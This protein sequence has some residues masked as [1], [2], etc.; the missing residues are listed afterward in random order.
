MRIISSE[1]LHSIQIIKKNQSLRI[2]SVTSITYTVSN[3]KQPAKW[4]AW[5][6]SSAVL[7]ILLYYQVPNLGNYQ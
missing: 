5:K 4:K 7:F 2:Q 6:S 1:V 3:E